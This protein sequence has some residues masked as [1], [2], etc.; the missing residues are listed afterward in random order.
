MFFPINQCL[1]S[2]LNFPQI[3]NSYFKI[4]KKKLFNKILLL[5][6]NEKTMHSYIEG[7]NMNFFVCFIEY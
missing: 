7:K 3:F 5:I 6:M 1:K 2:E 4:K